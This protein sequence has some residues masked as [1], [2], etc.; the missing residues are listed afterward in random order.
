MSDIRRIGAGARMSKAVIHGSTVYTAGQVAEKTKGGSVGDQTREILSLIDQILSEAGSEKE[1]ILSA[2]EEG[3]NVL[4]SAHG[5]S[6]RASDDEQRASRSPPLGVGS[7]SPRTSRRS[8][9]TGRV[10]ARSARRDVHVA[11]DWWVETA[12]FSHSW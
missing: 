9:A 7:L 12:P 6:L 8:G 11:R 3:K 1:K 4:I 10:L 5:N 2:L